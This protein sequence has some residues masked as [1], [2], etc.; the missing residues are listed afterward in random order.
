MNHAQPNLVF[1]ELALLPPP[2]PR[3]T[4]LTLG[5]RRLRCRFRGHPAIHI[6]AYGRDVDTH[7]WW[8]LFR[9]WRCFEYE[10]C[11]EGTEPLWMILP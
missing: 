10:W 2:E 5:L 6:E 7:L 11:P 4:H 8:R 3:L 1:M 9:C